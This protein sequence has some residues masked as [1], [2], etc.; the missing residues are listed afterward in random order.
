MVQ[1]DRATRADIDHLLKWAVASWEEL[2]E[3]EREI[4]TWDLIDQ[5]VFIEEWPLEEERLRRL[6]KHAQAN[7]LTEA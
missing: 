5:I 4:D 3:V 1:V 6:A 2:T 7:D